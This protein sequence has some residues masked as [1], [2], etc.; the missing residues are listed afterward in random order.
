MGPVST[1]TE[2]N[3]KV[4]EKFQ[5]LRLR[6]QVRNVH[7]EGVSMRVSMPFDFG[8]ESFLVYVSHVEGQ[9]V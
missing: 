3:A 1:L 8:K 7:N 9:P 6:I 4:K 5:H 2:L